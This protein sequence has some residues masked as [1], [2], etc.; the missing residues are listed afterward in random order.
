MTIS[1]AAKPLFCQHWTSCDVMLF[2]T[3]IYC[4]LHACLLY[5]YILNFTAM[6]ILNLT[7][8]VCAR[9]WTTWLYI[10]VIMWMLSPFYLSLFVVT[11]SWPHV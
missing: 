8:T 9:K 5:I 2:Y 11:T 4:A 1:V 6:Y 3:F 10:V 7:A